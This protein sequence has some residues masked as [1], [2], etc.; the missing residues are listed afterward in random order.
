LGLGKIG[1][2]VE[3]PDEPTVRGAIQV[4]RHLVKV[5]DA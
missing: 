5:D 3:R 2:T 1:R 4:V